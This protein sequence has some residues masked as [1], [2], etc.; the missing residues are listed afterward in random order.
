M[1]NE[2][3]DGASRAEKSHAE[4]RVEVTPGSRETEV[5]SKKPLSQH[6]FRSASNAIREGLHN[7]RFFWTIEFIPSRD[8]ILHDELHKLLVLPLSYALRISPR[9]SRLHHPLAS[10]TSLD[11]RHG[12]A[13][14]IRAG[15]RNLNTER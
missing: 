7:G 15:S 2:S 5:I 13:H 9:R 14:W 6:P 11:L 12:N 1:M 10:L 4:V 8:K 3:V